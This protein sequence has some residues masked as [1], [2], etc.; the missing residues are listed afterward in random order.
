[1]RS[2]ST[3]LYVL[4]SYTCKL[5]GIHLVGVRFQQTKKASERSKSRRL[6]DYMYNGVS[7][8]FYQ[9]DT[10]TSLCRLPLRNEFCY[11]R[12]SLQFQ[13]SLL[14][15]ATV[16]LVLDGSWMLSSSSMIT[17]DFTLVVGKLCQLFQ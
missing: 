15:V 6:R 9:L 1:M 5:T 13:E 16:T 14:H 11:P 4:A 3:G 10:R 2:A 12:K 17:Q 7:F 8:V